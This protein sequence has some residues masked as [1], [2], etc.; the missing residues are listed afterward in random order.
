MR[1]LSKSPPLLLALLLAVPTMSFAGEIYGKIVAGGA[2]VGDGATVEMKCGKKTY[3]AVQ[4][5]KT[6]SYHVVVEET[7]KCSLTVTWNKQS[8]SLDVASYDEAV[9]ADLVLE[10]K[11]GKLTARRK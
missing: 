7:G 6:G 2:P 3:P 1:K 4:T 8:A 5:D 11:D 10:V 9:Q